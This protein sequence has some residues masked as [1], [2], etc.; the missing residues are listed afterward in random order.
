[1]LEE[2]TAKKL[3]LEE[4]NDRCEALMDMCAA[5]WVRDKTVGLQG[6]YSAAV[7]A[8]QALLTRVQKNLADHTEFV[9]AREAFDAWLSRA[10]GTV[11]DCSGVGDAAQTAD[12]LETIK[13]VSQRLTE[14]QLLLSQAQEAFARAIDVAPVDQQSGL[15][16][17]VARLRTN[18]DQFNL[19][20]ASVQAQLKAT[21]VR[22]EDFAES[23]A[24]LEK[25]LTNTESALSEAQ[26]SRGELGEIK[27]SLERI[28]HLAIEIEAKGEDV[29]ELNT[30]GEELAAWAPRA[31]VLGAVTELRLRWEALT[32]LVKS[33]RDS[34][35]REISEYC[36]YHQRLQE[37][38][39]WLLQIS[40]QLMAHNSLYITSREQT[41]EQVSAH[42]SLLGNFIIID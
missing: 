7:T 4:L 8:L 39:K 33:R 11:Q 29:A 13:L 17:E 2:A 21:Q 25:W 37:T 20:L 31:A 30:A 40:F 36:A 28:K 6:G 5:T 26:D 41:Q 24:R 22:W 9:R 3:T 18:W 38:E 42:E 32:S 35:E 23:Q 10:Q 14:G 1:M 15:R 27:T 16:E 12:H 19:D 34:V